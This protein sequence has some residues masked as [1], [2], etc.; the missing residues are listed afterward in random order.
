MVLSCTDPPPP[1]TQNLP[2][3]SDHVLGI[4]PFALYILQH[5]FWYAGNR[6]LGSYAVHFWLE[7]TFRDSPALM[8]EAICSSEV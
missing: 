6:L 3:A 8:M 2:L 1:T 7:P 5:L 4:L